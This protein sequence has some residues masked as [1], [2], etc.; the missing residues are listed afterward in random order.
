ME[1]NEVPA[2]QELLEA[3]ELNEVSGGIDED[4]EEST[5]PG[6]EPVI[7]EPENQEAAEQEGYNPKAKD[8]HHQKP[9]EHECVECGK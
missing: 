1:D 4:E 6:R 9:T 7:L 8:D 2:D 3:S 5:E